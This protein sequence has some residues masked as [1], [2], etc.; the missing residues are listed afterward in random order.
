M[1]IPFGKVY[2]K[3]VCTVSKLGENTHGPLLNRLV[4]QPGANLKIEFHNNMGMGN[5]FRKRLYF[6][7]YQ[8]L[9]TLHCIPT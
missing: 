4:A 5:T 2:D 6:V 1:I 9:P 8:A 7:A 3:R